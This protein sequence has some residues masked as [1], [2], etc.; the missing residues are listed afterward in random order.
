MALTCATDTKMLRAGSHPALGPLPAG[1]GHECAGRVVARGLGV[2]GV[3]LGERVVPG[4]SAPCDRCRTCRRGRPSLCAEPRF[5]T[6]AFAPLLLVPSRIVRRNLLR[7]PDGLAPEIAAMAEPLA[8]AIRGVER[9]GA[10]RGDAAVVLGGG[11]QGVFLSWLL[12]RRGCRVVLCDPH[13]ERRERALAFGAASVAAP[14]DGSGALAE[15]V[16]LTAGGADVVMVAVGRAEAWRQAF[17]VVRPGGEVNLHGGCP[18]GG[19]IHLDAHRLHYDEVTVRGSFHHTPET[20]RAAMAI[21]SAGEM[22]ARA[23]LDAPIG[24]ADLARSL[25]A[26]GD[27]RP[28]DVLS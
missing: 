21:L 26:G 16:E 13:L 4:N 2:A 9:S 24:L 22:P 17:D 12:A 15:L 25:A 14:P 18:P 6:G 8:C 7:I 20:L 5:L 28:V 1:F 27:K 11:P 19:E 10:G 3:S 23:L